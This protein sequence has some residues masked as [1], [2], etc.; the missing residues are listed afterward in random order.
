[1]AGV[2][3]AFDWGYFPQEIPAF[4]RSLTEAIISRG[5]IPGLLAL[6]HASGTAVIEDF[7]VEHI[8]TGRPIIYTS[9]DS[10]IQIAAHEQH[11]GLQRLYEICQ[12]A[13]DLTY[14][15][16]IG[17]VI[18]RPFIGEAPGSFQRT[19][20]RK[21]FAV[22]PPSPTLLD[23]LTAAGRPVISIGKIGDIFAHSGTGQEWKVSGHPALMDKTLKAIDELGEG[24]FAMVNF[25]DF[26]TNFGHRRDPVG[27]GRLLEDFDRQIPALLSRLK[28]GDLVIF[29]ADHGNDP[30]WKGTDHTR[31]QVPV[32]VYG[33][34]M[35]PRDLGHR[36]S[37]A[38]TGQSIA[39][40]LGVGPLKAGTTFLMRG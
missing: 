29:T 31:E 40:Y 14:E 8:R 32:M 16:N 10:V 15:L 5:R 7:G 3:L 17:R 9:A 26:D 30:T 19:G 2:P 4:P 33:R 24:G 22:R 39:A 1:M 6:C 36:T 11:F 23:V 13:R 38:D 34:D 21:D 20:N 28:A 37:F 18:A 35:A 25:V 27:Y 12:I